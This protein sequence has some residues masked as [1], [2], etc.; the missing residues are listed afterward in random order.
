MILQTLPA[1]VFAVGRLDKDSCGL[2]LL[3]NDGAFA[4]RLLHPQYHHQKTYQ[5][6]VDKPLQPSMLQQLEQGM[7]YQDG[8]DWH[9]ARPCRVRLLAEDVVEL[10]LTEGKNR[11]IRYM[12]RQLGLKVLQLARVKI[13]ALTGLGL[14]P[15]Q[16]QELNAEQVALAAVA[17][18]E[19]T[20]V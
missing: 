11:Q 3:T 2:L 1:G 15:G 14:T 18:S 16:L 5:V 9:N 13:G 10:Q 4:Q 20:A 8:H 6:L 17:C 12:C 7:R 19:D